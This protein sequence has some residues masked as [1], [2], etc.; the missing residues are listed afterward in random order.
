[1][2][3]RLF[4]F[5]FFLTSLII[6]SLL[7]H[8]FFLEDFKISKILLKNKKKHYIKPIDI[9]SKISLILNQK[10]HYLTKGHHAYAFISE[11]KKYIIKFPRIHKF[12]AHFWQY[13]IPL[14][15]RDILLKEERFKFTIN[16][17]K[18][19][20][21]FL[22]DECAII[23]SQLDDRRIKKKIKLVDK[24]KREKK[25][26]LS[27][28]FFVLQKNCSLY[29][30]FLPKLIQNDDDEKI[31]I[32]ITSYFDVIKKR[33]DKMITN[34]DRRGFCRNYGVIN[35]YSKAYEIDIGSYIINPALK[36]SDEKQWEL[37]E[38][39]KDFR[40]YL[41]KNYPKILVFFD[42]KI[43]NTF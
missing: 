9:N 18:L 32:L 4:F 34:K 26:C 31:K 17:H 2:I 40:K 43:K 24:L 33:C 15:K 29:E 36:N 21:K 30:S 22:K 23:Y 13:F 11:N 38:C 16:S 37:E 14:L 19:A 28:T 6:S 41:K 27:Q 25:V 7:F 8:S 39:S 10:F 3:K 35:N 12:K 5:L 1:M 42:N 20:D